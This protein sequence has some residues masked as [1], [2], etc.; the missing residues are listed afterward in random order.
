MVYYAYAK[1]SNDDW[2]W[3]YMIIAPSYDVLNQW[4]EAV[5]AR[6]ADNVIW[7]VSEDFYVF[8]RTKLNLGRSTAPNA[9]APQFMNKLIF[10]LQNDNEGR[11]I[12][13]FNNSWN[14]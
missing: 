4:F 9:E 11:G 7:R 1:N 12:S 3:R 8:D 10:Q 13:T 5:K 6:V 14:R 2:S